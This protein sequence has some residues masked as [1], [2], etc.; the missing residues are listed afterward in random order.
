MITVKH[1]LRQVLALRDG[2]GHIHAA[3]TVDST[4]LRWSTAQ[5]DIGNLLKFMGSA[6]GIRYR[7]TAQVIQSLFPS[8][9]LLFFLSEVIHYDDVIFIGSHLETCSGTGR[10]V[11]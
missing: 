3:V 5:A 6:V 9:H 4:Y 2:V 1:I 10:T 11:K 8:P 7:D